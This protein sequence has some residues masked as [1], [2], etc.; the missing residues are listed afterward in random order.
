MMY[1]ANEQII[2]NHIDQWNQDYTFILKK[3]KYLPY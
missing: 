1:G 2:H 3:F